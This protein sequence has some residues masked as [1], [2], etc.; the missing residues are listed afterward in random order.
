MSTRPTDWSPLAGSDPTPGDPGEVATLAN[1]YR[2]TADEISRQAANLRRLASGTGEGWD[3]DAGRVFHDHADELAGKIEKAHQRYDATAS[4]LRGFVSPLELAQRQADQ[5][6]ADAKEASS[7][8]AS[9]A[10]G[11]SPAPGDKPPTPE[12]Q[13]AERRRQAAY[14][15]ASGRLGA[16]RRRMDDAKGDYEHAASTAAKAIRD[17]IDHDDVH[18]GFWDKV[19]NWI[20][21]HADI[22]KLVLKVVGYIVTVLAIAALVIALFIPGL[23]ILVMGVALA[24]ILETAAV[25]G[26]VALL[27]GHTALASTGDGSWLDVGLDIVA[28]ATFGV[29]K[30][31]T[32]GAEGTASAARSVAAETAATRATDASLQ[33][34]RLPRTLYGLADRI[35]GLRTLVDSAGHLQAY[36]DAARSAG[37]LARSQVLSLAPGTTALQR[38]L[39]A[40]EELPA[41]LAQLRAIDQLVP[42]V[43]EIAQAS[44]AVSHAGVANA[45]LTDGGL[46][47]DGAGHASEDL[48]DWKSRIEPTFTAPLIHLP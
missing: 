41:R 4:A 26:T 29:G 15:D 33:S 2:N 10:A 34:T 35:P 18:D 17:V 45:V 9:H 12:E 19:G 22:I 42:G 47:L 44:T 11:P 36:E 23:N 8:M 7:D 28:L 25:V 5:A 1:R 39:F 20:H 24:T 13:S 40:S 32:A 3:S 38:A 37:T 43:P 16:A 31:L 21:E 30:A 48:V 27:I 14:D 46:V 6:L